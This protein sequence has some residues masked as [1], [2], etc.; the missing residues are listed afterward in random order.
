MKLG[1]WTFVLTEVL[2]HATNIRFIV[3]VSWE[4]NFSKWLELLIVYAQLDALC[5]LFT[6]LCAVIL[7]D[8]KFSEGIAHE[9]QALVACTESSCQ[10]KFI[11]V[12]LLQS[13]QAFPLLDE[14]RVAGIEV[15]EVGILHAW[16]SYHGANEL[17]AVD[18]AHLLDVCEV[19][20][21]LGEVSRQDQLEL[22]SFVQVVQH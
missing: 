8:A 10:F 6:I 18:S 13:I 17:L 16:P 7:D 14:R 3:F 2:I 20:A 21:V 15:L 1:F 4:W 22:H 19:H 11:K 12:K 9:L 5:Y